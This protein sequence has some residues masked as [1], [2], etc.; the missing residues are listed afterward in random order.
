MT[1]VGL[2]GRSYVVSLRQYLPDDRPRSA[3]HLFARELVAKLF[4]FERAYEEIPA[5]GCG[6][7]LYFDFYLPGLRLLAEVQGEQHRKY[8]PWFHH[9]PEGFRAQRRRDALKRE[10]CA[11]NKLTLCSLDD[12]RRDEWAD[13]LRQA[14][15]GRSGL[16]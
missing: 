13:V 16:A 1:F 4:P 2:D 12:D 7:A 11:A 5:N 9:T 6:T 15:Y 8:V 14:V 3:G 10:W